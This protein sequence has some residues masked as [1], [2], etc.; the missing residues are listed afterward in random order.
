MSFV[1]GKCF[2]STTSQHLEYVFVLFLKEVYV[3]QGSISLN[4][5][6][7]PSY[8]SIILNVQF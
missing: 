1:A 3:H 4:K 6:S 8:C 7:N 2:F 5:Y